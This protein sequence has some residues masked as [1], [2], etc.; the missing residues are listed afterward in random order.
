VQALDSRLDLLRHQL[1]HLPQTQAL[2]TLQSSREEVANQARDTRTHV[3]DLTRD[4]RKAD[5]DVE[6]VKLR[7]TRDRER[8]DKGLVSNPKDLERMQHELVSLGRRIGALEDAELEVMEQLETAQRALDALESR[9]VE[10]DEQI[11]ATTRER[12]EKA[13]DVSQ[14]L[15][16]VTAQRA[17]S[18]EGLPEDL[19]ALYSRL[20][21]QKGGVGAAALRAR[22]CSGCSLQVNASDLAVVAKAPSDE[23]LR[24]E[25]CSR[26]LVRTDESGI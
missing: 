11:A 19:L 2:R 10:L 13:G 20:R 24:C 18:V 25:D 7:R 17:E 1:D 26:I 22:R 6:Q 5:A 21:Q 15:G 23:V 9:L 14:Q 3:Q 8:I 4:Q 16:E 12:D